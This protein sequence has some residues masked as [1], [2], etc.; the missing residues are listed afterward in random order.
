MNLNEKKR[1]ENV[2][3]TESQ[4]FVEVYMDL[5]KKGFSK[6]ET[7]LMEETEKILQE[8]GINLVKVPE[9]VSPF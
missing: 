3:Q 8:K 4:T 2:K 7:A 5:F 9:K 6:D 1:S